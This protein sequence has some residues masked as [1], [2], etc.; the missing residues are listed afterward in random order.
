M[1]AAP[2]RV[3]HF[4]DLHLL[5]LDGAR[6]GDFL[7]NKRLTGAVNL[8]LHRGRHYLTEVFDR[9]VDDLN[10]QDVDHVI[11][12][13]DITNLALEAEFRFARERFARLKHTAQDV[14]CVPGNHDTYIAEVAGLFEQSFDPYCTS[15]EGWRWP[16]GGRWPIVRVRGDLAVIGLSTS[17]P[18]TWFMGHGQVGTEQL[19]RLES[20]LLDPRLAGKFRLIA[21]HHPSAGR[22]ARSVRRG[23]RDHEAFAK[24]LTR[25]GV[26]LVLHGHEHIDLVSSLPGLGGPVPVRGIQSGT[27]DKDHPLKRA[28]YRVYEIAGNRLVGEELRTWRTLK[29]GFEAEPKAA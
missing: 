25:T 23:L 10:E 7:V 13:G 3:A 21:M 14:T 15:D 12:T 26:E 28:R 20:V 2:M 11:C 16:D 22:H 4:S 24:V 5:S 17:Y 18:T 27:Y 1:L 6:L 19:A 29:K 8:L 9:M